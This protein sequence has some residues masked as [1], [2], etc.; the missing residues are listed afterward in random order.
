MAL[1]SIWRFWMVLLFLS[2]TLSLGCERLQLQQVLNTETLSKL[3]AMGGPFPRH[4]IRQRLSLKTKP[5]NLVKLSKELEDRI[6]IVHQTL[7]HIS[8][9]YSMNLGS[10]TWARDKVE[11][12]RLLLDRQ[13]GELEECI[14]KTG[15]EHKLRRNSAIHNYF[16]KLEKFLKQEKFSDCAW[17][18][19]R[20]E[21]RARLQ[22]LL[23]VIAQ[24]SRRN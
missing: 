22:Q 19:I 20:T 12:F 15:S 6:Q 14:R 13:L 24:I 1:A 8:K 9:I 2:G 16:R 23:F 4:C 3:N 17:E 10:V 11:K 5:L 21:T 18:I 7:C